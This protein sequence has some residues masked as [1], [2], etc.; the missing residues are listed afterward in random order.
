MR[1][2]EKKLNNYCFGD[3]HNW[4]VDAKNFGTFSYVLKVAMEVDIECLK[5][6][7]KDQNSFKKKT[8]YRDILIKV[9]F[10]A[11][12]IKRHLQRHR[13]YCLKSLKRQWDNDKAFNLSASLS[14]TCR[15]FIKQDL[16]YNVHRLLSM[17]RYFQFMYR[18]Y[19]PGYKINGIDKWY[20]SQRCWIF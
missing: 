20:I 1:W 7:I 11:E 4:N 15:V 19:V 5:S 17:V 9:K 8:W 14:K 2:G 6:N 16:L 12:L 18:Y 3:K 10:F 13:F